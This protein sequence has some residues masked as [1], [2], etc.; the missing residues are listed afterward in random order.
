M[1]GWE[2]LAEALLRREV[3]RTRLARD[4]PPDPFA[5]LKLDEADVDRL[6]AGAEDVAAPTEADR[7]VERAR[8]A[9]AASIEGTAL[10][11]IAAHAQLGA[12]ETEVLALLAAIE[13]SPR[14]QRL[15]AYLADDVQQTRPTL[16][17]L[18]RIFGADGPLAVATD[19]ALRRAALV[20]VAGT[21]AWASRVVSLEPAVVW[22]LVGDGSLDPALPPGATTV[23]GPSPD[24][25]DLVFVAGE[26][27][28]RRLQSA[29]VATGRSS[30]L[31]V[32][33]PGDDA[34]WDA[35]VRTATI[36][37]AGVV[38][39]VASA[40]AP[41]TRARIERTPHL[42]WA[43]VSSTEIALDEMPLRRWVEVRADAP[44]A[45]ADE[46]LG[47][48]GDVDHQGHRLTAD[49]LRLV[50]P[51]VRDTGDINAAIRRLA[52][53]PFDKLARRVR[54]QRSWGDIVLAPD[55]LQA[56]KELASRYRHRD[57]VHGEWGFPA[58]PA[59]G[60]VAMFSGSSGT[61]KT[62]AA[63]IIAGELGLD[64]Y[65]LD[66]SSVVSKYIGETEKNLE[67]VFSAATATNTVLFFDEA[68]SLFGKRSEVTDARDRYANLEV[69][70]LL[71]RLEAYDGLVILATN[72]QKNIDEA[73]LRRIH[74]A[75]EFPMPAE[76]ERM[77]IW[78]HA[79][80]PAAP[81]K[82]L[83]FEFLARQ[84]DLA[85]G[86]IKGAALHAAFLAAEAGEPITMETVMLALKREF[87]KLGRL[88]TQNEFKQYTKLV[89][90]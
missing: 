82:D 7:D 14:R 36:F 2:A 16:H 25:D 87:Q 62:L 78:Q 31:V 44:A 84:F 10:G 30:F 18:Q 90:S 48:V 32:D 72:F 5:G 12:V 19:A 1:A 63:E 74:V 38:V 73:F 89:N 81:T 57:L 65:K 52:S 37:G 60:L 20:D 6:L 42:A 27:R 80:P 49:Q 61:G 28:V 9:A 83:D 43:V 24:G 8:A 23:N 69:S 13:L 50:Q 53:G 54:P 11:Q 88:R 35:V 17:L 75:I 33:E 34:Q 66:L 85:G 71:Q 51:L 76:P 29:V 41:T 58:I 70:Y 40:L 22:A 79:F 26:D 47:A 56:L 77:A 46:W 45:S 39:E 86:S 59:A 68:D 3:A 64:L 15:V 4:R 21:G 55:R 67:R